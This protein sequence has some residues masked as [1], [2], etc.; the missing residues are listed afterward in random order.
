ME[1]SE[2]THVAHD[3]QTAATP[4]VAQPASNELAERVERITRME[5]AFTDAAVAIL[6]FEQ[7]L[8]DFEAAQESIATLARY[9]GSEEWFADRAADE[10]GE[11]PADLERGVL[12]E[13]LPYD[14]LVSYR[15]LA[16]RMLK[17]ATHALED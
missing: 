5:Q 17:A 1:T 11:L 4:Q 16:L 8:D 6:G 10:A 3:A 14:L 9:Y 13:D 12:G 7:D 15:D 2:N